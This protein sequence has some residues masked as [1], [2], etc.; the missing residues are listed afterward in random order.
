[1]KNKSVRHHF[2]R[3]LILAIVSLS[4]IAASISPGILQTKVKNLTSQSAAPTIGSCSLF[5]ANNYWNVPVDALPVHALSAAWVNSIGATRHFHMDFG[6]GTW[7][8]GPIGIPFNVISGASTTKYQVDFYYPNQSDPGPYPIP[9]DPNIEYGSDH[10]L[11]TV[12]T[13]DCK[14]YE[15]YDAEKIG[16]QWSAGSGAIWD[17]NSNA[18][19]PETWTSADAAGLPILPGL[20]RY[21]EVA[22][23]EINHALRFTVNCS[24]DYYVWPARH[25]APSGSCATPVPFGARFRLKANYDI[26]GFSPEAQVILQAMKTYGIVNSDNGAPW[27]VSGAP[28]ENWD[29]DILHEL[30]VLTGSNFEA[31]DTSDLM[32]WVFGDVPDSYWAW[33]FVERLYTAGIT[34]GCGVSPRRYCPEGTVTRAQM[35]VFLERGIHSSSY[36]PPAIGGSTGFGDVDPTYWAAAWIKQLAAEGITG[37]CGNGNYCPES[38]VTRAQMA[39]FLL[40]SK[41]GA[42]YSPPAV[43]GS[44]GFGDVDPTYWA[45]AWIKQLVAEGITAGCG[46]G[47]Y[48]PESPVTRAQMAVFLVKT[49]NL[50]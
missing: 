14:L 46:A 28:D 47:I 22:A 36:N 7:D 31:V 5:P 24:A 17:L 3:F 45:A 11:L 9:Q 12:D 13:D 8:G 49:F 34:G 6:S 30:D 41:Y 20:A 15:I 42:S 39:V 25:I 21:E 50:P 40:R 23:G 43:G 2:F 27:F 44:T 37:G 4:T 1:M 19:R 16:G 32:P 26:S 29:N 10:H 33:N 18:L 35:A 48:C 38:P